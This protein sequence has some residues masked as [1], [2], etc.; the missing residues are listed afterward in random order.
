[1][2]LRLLRRL[3]G[4]FREF[5]CTKKRAAHLSVV[6][7]SQIQ[8]SEA[9]RQTQAIEHI[10]ITADPDRD[11]PLLMRD[12]FNKPKY[13]DNLASAVALNNELEKKNLFRH[14][15]SVIGHW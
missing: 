1:L 8:A 7:R 11:Y 14:Q 9:I 6:L 5:C 4:L 15:S 12:V 10:C 3:E 2:A 13:F